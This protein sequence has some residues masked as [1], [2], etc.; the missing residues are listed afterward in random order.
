MTQTRSRLIVIFILAA[1]IILGTLAFWHLATEGPKAPEPPS[2]SRLVLGT[3]T[4]GM[5]P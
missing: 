5:I 1:L 4:W 3:G 2:R